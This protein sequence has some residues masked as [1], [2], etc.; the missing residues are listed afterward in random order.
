MIAF[1]NRLSTQLNHV[2]GVL[3]QN[4]AA[5]TEGSRVRLQD[6]LAE[7]ETRRQEVTRLLGP[8]LDALNAVY[9]ENGV[10]IVYLP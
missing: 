1:P 7:W 8:E 4:A 10:P 5:I 6:L 3:D 9:R 2:M